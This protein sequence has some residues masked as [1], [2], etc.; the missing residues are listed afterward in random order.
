MHRTNVRKASDREPVSGRGL[1][2]ARIDLA[3]CG[4]AGKTEAAG[5]A[6]CRSVESERKRKFIPGGRRGT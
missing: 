6:S 3:P 5:S 4:H 1:A 2:V